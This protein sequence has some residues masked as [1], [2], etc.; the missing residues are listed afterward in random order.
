MRRRHRTALALGLLVNVGFACAAPFAHAQAAATVATN[1]ATA[2]DPRYAALP[3]ITFR[4]INTGE[5]I[6][7]RL[8]RTDGTVDPVAVERLGHLLRDLA[9]DEPSPVVTRTLQLL[10]RV[11]T[12]FGADTIE[13]VSGYRSG[14][15]RRGHRVRREGYHSV[16]SAIDFRMP[17]QDMLRVA[18][19]ARTF[20]HVGVG[21]YP[22][23]GFVHLDSR[24]QSFHWENHAGHGHHGWDRPLDRAACVAHDEA[25][26]AAQDAPWDPPGA[27]VELVLHPPTAEGARRPRH[28]RRDGHH[29]GSHRHHAPLRVFENH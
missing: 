3:E 19:Y 23:S 25:W 9:T 13:V 11:A 12:H 16:G 6:R 26:T 29:R 17:G 18:A 21:W 27:P 14:R 4:A 7:V 20:G 22:T 15:N 28:A 24:E 5:E 8:Y 2:N 10:V 1:V